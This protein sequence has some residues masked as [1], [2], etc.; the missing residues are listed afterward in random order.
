M[1]DALRF[2]R[3]ASSPIRMVLTS[4]VLEVAGS[5]HGTPTTTRFVFPNALSCRPRGYNRARTLCD[6]LHS[7]SLAR[8][9]GRGRGDCHH[10][11]HLRSHRH[12]SGRSRCCGR[13]PRS[14]AQTCPSRGW[15]VWM[16]Q[17]L[18]PGLQ[19]RQHGDR[20]RPR[21]VHDRTAGG[22]HRSREA[23]AVLN[24]QSSR[25]GRLLC[26]VLSAGARAR[27]RGRL[28]DRRRTPVLPILSLRR[29][30]GGQ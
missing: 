27:K 1:A 17:G 26:H 10:L 5:N 3:H 12:G 14:V 23:R 4:S 20:L 22:S 9:V 18:P 2:A 8:L 30:S 24:P 16:L 19:R 6:Y 13:R 25:G 15:S 11:Q 7:V 29:R 28:V 21:C